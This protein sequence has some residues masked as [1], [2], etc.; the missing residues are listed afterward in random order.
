MLTR[1]SH[2]DYRRVRWKNGLGWTTELAV[3]PAEGEF[4]W[5]VSIAEVDADCQFS[6]FP[7]IDRS[8]LVLSGEGMALTVGDQ[9]P[10]HLRAGGE[11]LV[12]SGDSPAR[13]QLLDGPTRDFNVMTRRGVIEHELTTQVLAG[14]QRLACPPGC[15]L[16]VHVSEG[17]VELEGKPVAT[18]ESVL[19]GE[20]VE[21]V[22]RGLLVLVRL[23]PL[24]DPARPSDVSPGHEH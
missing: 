13:A 5:R 23:R 10:V 19:V 20:P 22:G 1:F 16:F 18:G 17:E 14:S 21:L 3:Q 2:A 15:S 12:F 6:C 24:S 9:L 8:I 7:G 11:P 4:D